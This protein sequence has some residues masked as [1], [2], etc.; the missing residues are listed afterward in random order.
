MVKMKCGLGMCGRCN[1][2]GQVSTKGD[3]NAK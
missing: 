2:E 1:I 3:D